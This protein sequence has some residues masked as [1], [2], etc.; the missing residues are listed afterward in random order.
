[1]RFHC[2]GRYEFR[3]TDRKRA[4]FHRKQ[5]AEREALPLFA[6]QVAAEQIGADEEMEGR[7][8]RWERHQANDRQRR[9][10]KWRE[11]RRRLNDYPVSVRGGLLAYWQRCMWPGDPSYFLSMLHMYDNGRLSIDTPSTAKD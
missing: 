1:M 8:Q 2:Y 6:D 4:A 3:D 9:A 7:R 10:E 11:A 5:R